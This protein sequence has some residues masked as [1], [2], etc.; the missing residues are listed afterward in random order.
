MNWL[1]PVIGGFLL[2]AAWDGHRKGFIKKS[3]GIVTMVLTLIITGIAVPYSAAFF[4]E[5]TALYSVLQKGIASSEIDILKTL[6][7][8]GLKEALSSYLA[9]T[10]LQAAAFLV[11][12]LL[13]GVLVQG[14]AFS[15]GIAAKLPVLHGINKLAGLVLGLAEGVLAVWIFFFAITVC[16]TTEWG[17]KLLLMIAANDILSWI[18]RSNLLFVFLRM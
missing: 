12:L 14:L 7:S 15:L 8:I 1:L 6:E 5:K 4:R 10:I 9:E 13:V 11:T 17:G 3:V 18:Y 2:L 16:S